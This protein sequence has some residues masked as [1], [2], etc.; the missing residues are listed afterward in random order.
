MRLNK[1][2]QEAKF[3]APLPDKKTNQ[4]CI[5]LES[6]EDTER[7]RADIKVINTGLSLQPVNT[8]FLQDLEVVEVDSTQLA[9]HEL[10]INKAAYTQATRQVAIVS[11]QKIMLDLPMGA[12]GVKPNVWLTIE[13]KDRDELTGTLFVN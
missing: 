6:K 4:L 10:T 9:G 7:P 12:Q 3:H 2:G 11:E 5:V 1:I 8:N 13:D